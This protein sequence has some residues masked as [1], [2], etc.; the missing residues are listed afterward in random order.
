MC[1]YCHNCYNSASDAVACG[2]CTGLEIQWVRVGIL[3]GKA[4]RER[5]CTLEGEAQYANVQ[6]WCTVEGSGL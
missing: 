5:Q 2:Y 1:L 6:E 3:A 4:L